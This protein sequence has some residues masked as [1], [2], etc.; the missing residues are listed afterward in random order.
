MQSSENITSWLGS[1]LIVLWK[2]NNDTMTQ[3]VSFQTVYLLYL[4][5]SWMV[6]LNLVQKKLFSHTPLL[7]L[8][9][10]VSGLTLQLSPNLII[11]N[12]NTIIIAYK[13]RSTSN[14]SI[15]WRLNTFRQSP[16]PHHYENIKNKTVKRDNKNPMLQIL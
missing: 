9:Y 3:L 8:R 5:A 4:W 13:I 1:L 10:F 15:Y 12:T 7:L 6:V 14:G 16:L 11:L 2:L